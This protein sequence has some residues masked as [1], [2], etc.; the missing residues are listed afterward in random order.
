[1]MPKIMI[2]ILFRHIRSFK[3]DRLWS[4]GCW[5]KAI[6]ANLLIKAL[7]Q[8]TFIK[9]FKVLTVTKYNLLVITFEIYVNCDPIIIKIFLYKFIIFHANYLQNFWV[10]YETSL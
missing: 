3:H 8:Q 7:F 5:C 2:F 10:Y 6:T 9:L 4:K 1:M